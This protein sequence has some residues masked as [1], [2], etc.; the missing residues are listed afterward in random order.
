[1]ES[2]GGSCDCSCHIYYDGSEE[3]MFLATAR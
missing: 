1:L 3:A 2:N